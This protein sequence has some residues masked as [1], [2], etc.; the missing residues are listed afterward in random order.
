MI[1]KRTCEEGRSE[2]GRPHRRRSCRKR[3]VS[4]RSVSCYDGEEHHRNKVGEHVPPRKQMQATFR[5]MST[6]VV[7][8]LSFYYPPLIV[9]WVHSADGR[10]P[11]CVIAPE[12]AVSGGDRRA[13]EARRL[14]SSRQINRYLRRHRRG[15]EANLR[16]GRATLQRTSSNRS[17]SSEA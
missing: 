7:H 9:P 1:F 15:L 16:R 5:P 2:E 3:R 10:F 6:R 4:K 12:A 11:K 17:R 8:S 14:S 13:A